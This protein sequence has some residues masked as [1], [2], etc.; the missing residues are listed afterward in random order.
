MT[1]AVPIVVKKDSRGHLWQISCYEYNSITVLPGSLVSTFSSIV[2]FTTDVLILRYK[3][4][5]S[6]HISQCIICSN[7]VVFFLS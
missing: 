1:A 5:V 4:L 6:F 2:R 7:K 3:S